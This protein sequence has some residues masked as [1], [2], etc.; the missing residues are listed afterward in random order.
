MSVLGT[1]L[2]ALA[3]GACGG[4]SSVTRSRVDSS[5]ASS[6][7]PSRAIVTMV[8][9]RYPE[10]LDPALDY[11]PQGAEVN[12]V[13]YTGL[14]TYTHAS[15]LP[16]ATLIPGLATALPKISAGGRTYTVTLRR[17]LRYSDG[18]PVRASDFTRAVQRAIRL[19]WGGAGQFVTPVI[20]GGAAFAA[21]RSKTISGITANDA[22]GRITIHLA[23]PYGPFDNVLAY[24]SLGLVP[25]DTPLRAEPTDPPPGA[26]PYEV[27]NI[28][29]GHSYTV[30]RNPHWTALP[31]IG[32]G[33]VRQINVRV[34]GDL[35]ANAQAVLDG[36]ADV[37]DAAD[38]L[39]A[40]VLAQI[41]A[42][43]AD[44]FTNVDVGSSTEYIFFDT[45]AK[46]FDS[47]LAR[48]AVVIALDENTMSQLSAGALSP[49]CYFLPDAV[50]GHPTA[51]CPYGTPGSGN[52]AAARK[53][54]KRAG[55]A[56]A[57]VTVWSPSSTPRRQWMAY[58]TALLNRIGFKATQKVL[59]DPRYFAAIGTTKLQAQ[60]GFADWNED[61]ADPVDFYLLLDGDAI[62]PTDNENYGQVDDSR[63]DSAIA[64]LGQIPTP[65]LASDVAKWQQLDQY[66]A[67]RAYVAVFGYDTDPKLMSA[68]MDFGA[69][70]LQPVYGW[71]FTSLQL[72]R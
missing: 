35:T 26:G 50:P 67:R 1:S 45:L 24:P 7:A 44:R 34:S 66:T 16:G 48:E 5:T 55:V 57:R 3:L 41:H 40:G 37:F 68:R 25:S 70:I 20:A 42:K 36:S 51:P 49:G 27:T 58:Y 14:T 2:L 64:T 8:Q 38:T 72:T 33:H 15:G 65:Q 46:P 59:P 61:F 56:G 6:S 21:G 47:Q 31:G 11:S 19:H 39:P 17:G 54:V 29:P 4:S 63:I 22:T 69:A 30:L 9:G 60:T 28:V 62:E 12:W 18:Q 13:V 53:L 71:D 23:A 10:S 43:A 52:V 32:A